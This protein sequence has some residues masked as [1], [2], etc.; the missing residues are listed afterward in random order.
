MNK[1]KISD[2]LTTEEA[3]EG[4]MFEQVLLDKIDTYLK[5]DP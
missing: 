1:I 3:N 4:F 5:I 2:D